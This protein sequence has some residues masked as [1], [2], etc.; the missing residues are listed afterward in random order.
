MPFAYDSS[1]S[2]CSFPTAVLQV[3]QKCSVAIEFLGEEP[4]MM[5]RGWA[6]AEASPTS[7]LRRENDVLR[8]Q[9]LP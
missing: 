8:M 4:T 2:S 9:A 5:S 6:D 7:Q 1:R 3:T